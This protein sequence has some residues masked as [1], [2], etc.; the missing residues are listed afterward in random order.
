MS[1]CLSLC[2]SVQCLFVSSIT[3]CYKSRLFQM[4]V[5]GDR[6]VFCAK[7][8]MEIGAVVVSSLIVVV[9]LIV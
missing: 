1:V 6:F 4:I 5:L 8:C 7:F 9:V 2:M 3:A